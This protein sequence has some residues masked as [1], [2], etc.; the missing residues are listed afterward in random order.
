M[1]ESE[2]VLV[3][4]I[5][6]GSG[7]L[8]AL[9]GAIA[10]VVGP[11]WLKKTELQAERTRNEIEARRKAIVEFS[12]KKLISMQAYHQV[13]SLGGK[14]DS[15][16]CKIE[17]AN[18]SANELYSYIKKEDGA[19][20][21]WING[22]GFRAISEKPASM[23]DLVKIDAFLGIGIQYL[24]AWH[25]G[26]LRTSDLRPFGLDKNLKPVWLDSW[27]SPWPD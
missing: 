25:V 3:A 7:I 5:T 18:Q 10:A 2:T 8:G 27:E 26:E 13:F 1:I 11:W 17:N 24:I 14:D 4:L 19:V 23:D 12:N 15:L 22:M 9:L 20:K 21:K 6:A 16:I